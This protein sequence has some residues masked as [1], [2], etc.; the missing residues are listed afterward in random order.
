MLRSYSKKN[1]IHCY[2]QPD[3]CSFTREVHKVWRFRRFCLCWILTYESLKGREI[4]SHPSL[5]F[6]NETRV[7]AGAC[8]KKAIKFR[9]SW[10][11]IELSIF[12]KK[13]KNKKTKAINLSQYRHSFYFIFFFMFLFPPE[14]FGKFS[15]N[16]TRANF[17][18]RWLYFTDLTFF[19]FWR[20][21]RKGKRTF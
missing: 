19:R 12:E 2:L 15:Y 16:Y 1:R 5:Y 3:L 4:L 20:P 10:H 21:K 6:E 7:P 17:R 13:G 18:H 9:H 11:R 14:A 8:N